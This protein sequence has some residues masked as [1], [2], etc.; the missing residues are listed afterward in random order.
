[1]KTLL[2]RRSHGKS[3]LPDIA[4]H[5]RGD[6]VAFAM[7]SPESN[8][9]QIYELD[10]D[11]DDPPVLT[12]GQDESRTNYCPCWTPDGTQLIAISQ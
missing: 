7:K 1:M 9:E 6:R 8:R 10:P 11:F 4:W 2:R 5:P 12:A 3:F